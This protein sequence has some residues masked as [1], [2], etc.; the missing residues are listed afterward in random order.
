MYRSGRPGVGGP[1]P[2]DAGAA[3]GDAGPAILANGGAGT[4]RTLEMV[5]DRDVTT[6]LQGRT[7]CQE[8]PFS[9]GSDG[10]RQA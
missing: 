9:L 2:S 4:G 8:S 7:Y 5:N 10:G 6:L 1:G 3:L